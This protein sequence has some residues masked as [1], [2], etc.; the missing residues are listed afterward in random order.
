MPESVEIPA[1]VSTGQAADPA[2]PRRGPGRT[3]AGYVRPHGDQTLRIAILAEDTHG[4]ADGATTAA[5]AKPA[6]PGL[7]SV[8]L[9]M[10]MKVATSTRMD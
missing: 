5:L 7:V 10:R 4:G 9:R 2:R 1:P 3:I 8:W 6:G